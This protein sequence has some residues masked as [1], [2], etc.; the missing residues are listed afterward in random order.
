MQLLASLCVFWY[1]FSTEEMLFYSL[2]FYFMEE[3]SGKAPFN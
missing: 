2:N 3:N 1:L